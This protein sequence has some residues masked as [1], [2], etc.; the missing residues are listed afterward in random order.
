MRCTNSVG[1]KNKRYLK[2]MVTPSTHV[3]DQRLLEGTF[4]LL[5][6]GDTI[7]VD[8]LGR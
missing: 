2:R 4:P 3:H 6:Q 8:F 5:V 7:R 1:L